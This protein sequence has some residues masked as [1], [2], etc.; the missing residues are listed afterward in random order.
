[1]THDK[2]FRSRRRKGFSCVSPEHFVLIRDALEE[3]P[4]L[5]PKELAYIVNNALATNYS[6]S[7]VDK[8]MRYNKISRKL[9]EFCPR[10]RTEAL[11]RLFMARVK[12]MFTSS[13]LV[14]VDETHCN[15]GDIVR[16]YGYAYR[17]LAPFVRA[18]NIPHGA[19]S[20]CSA[21]CAM[22]LQGYVSITTVNENVN[23]EMFIYCLANHILPMMRPFPS[24]N[25]VL[26]LDNAA[27]HVADQVAENCQQH[28]VIPLF[29]PPYSYDLNP[30]EKS[31]H[32][33]KH[34]IRQ[35]YPLLDMNH[36]LVAQHLREGMSLITTE[37]AVNYFRDCGYP[38]TEIDQQ[39]IA[40]ITV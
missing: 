18:A 9:V 25:S 39:N 2:G 8:A 32:Q 20:P 21:I 13:Q 19:G 23:G 22:G 4:V 15:E 34:F 7:Q 12:H 37:N 6:G 35:R 24:P 17:G 30:I 36:N 31:F 16:K 1:M 10:E 40:A 26:I 14:F 27:V 11:R 38:V 33:A 5:Q 3:C 28:G 29:L